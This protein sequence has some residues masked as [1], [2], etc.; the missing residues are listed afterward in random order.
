VSRESQ[1]QVDGFLGQFEVVHGALHIEAGIHEKRCGI[2]VS[3]TSR[4]NRDA[5]AKDVAA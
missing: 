1:P 2:A 5:A 4:I 3:C